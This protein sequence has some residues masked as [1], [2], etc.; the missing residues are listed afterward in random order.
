MGLDAH[1]CCNCIEQGLLRSAPREE[2][3]VFLEEDGSRNSRSED[4]EVLIA[5]DRW[6]QTDACEHEDGIFTHHRIG[7]IAGVSTLRSA[8]EKSGLPFPIMLKSVIYSGT[9]SG[10]WLTVEQAWLLKREVD[11]IAL[12]NLADGDEEKYLR[13]FEINMRN[14]VEC[15]IRLNKPIAF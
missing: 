9:H 15:S 2:W 12:V 14:L 7:N 11:Q 4:L 10:D 8:L 5:F 6:N 3:G 13:D 1:V